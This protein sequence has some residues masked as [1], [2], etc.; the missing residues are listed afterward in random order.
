M[1]IWGTANPV[2]LDESYNG[3]FLKQSDI[4]HSLRNISGM[5]VKIEHKGIHVGKVV[6]GWE[7]QGKMDLLIDIDES[8]AEGSVVSALVKYGV[9]SELS[10]GYTVQMQASDIG[11]DIAKSKNI[12][13]VSLVRKGARNDCKIHFWVV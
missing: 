13:E 1:L 4:Q 8:V 12:S 10:L 11:E 9:C 7:N 5:P 6:S 2:G 3:Y